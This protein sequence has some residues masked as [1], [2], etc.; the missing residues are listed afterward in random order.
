MAVPTVN[1]VGAIAGGAGTATI[2]PGVSHTSGDIDVI[3][4]ECGAGDTP[5]LTTANGFARITALNQTV[6]SAPGAQMSIWWRRWNGSDGSPVFADAG[7]HQMGRMISVS[8]C[9]ATGDPWDITGT[10]TTD[11]S[12]DTSASIA[13]GTTTVAECLVLGFIC[14]EGPDTNSTTEFGSP[15]NGDLTSLTERVDNSRLAGGG[16]AVY[17]VSGEKSTAGAFGATTLTTATSSLRVCGILA[18][19]PPLTG[20]TVTPSVIARSFTVPAVTVKGSAVT[21]PSVIA[22]SFATPAVT[23]KG[24]AVTTPAAIAR[25]FTVPATTQKGG[26]VTTPAVISRSFT[27]PQVTAS[28][29]G[30]PG[31]VTPAATAT[32]VAIPSVTVKGSAVVAPAVTARSFTVPATTQKGGGVATPAVIARSFTVDAVTVKGAARTAPDVIARS[33][34]IPAVTTKGGLGVA[35]ATIAGNFALAAVTVKGGALVAPSVIPLSVVMPG[36]TVT[37]GLVDFWNYDPAGYTVNPAAY[38]V[39]PA[40]YTPVTKDDDPPWD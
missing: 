12:A 7:D 13:G 34:T 11:S 39:N 23:V 32:T 15:T 4:H 25:T 27:I 18:L 38:A 40:A 30:T 10:G 26:A 6:G 37:S 1:S 21:T 2:D 17:M 22:R 33:F 5:A 31:S 14:Q 3:V 35:P 19:K 29:G 36:V 9:I 20:T 28:A 8:G 24:S 16:G